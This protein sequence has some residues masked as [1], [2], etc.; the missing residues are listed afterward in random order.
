MAKIKLS[1]ALAHYDRHIPFFDG[2]LQSG[3]IDL[4]VLQVGQSVSERD[5]DNRHGRML[6]DG[7]FDAAEVS[8]S[9]YL[10]GR[11]RNL[12]FTA[13]PVFP[14]RLFS[15]SMIWVNKTAG[16]QTPADLIGKKI[17]LSSFQTTLSVLTKGDLQ[18]EY[19][20]PWRKIHWYTRRQETIDFKP[21]AGVQ[22]DLIPQESNI[23]QMFLAGDLDA[24]IM[25]HPPKEVTE[26]SDLIRRLFDNPRGEEL[27]YFQKNGFYPI[28]HVI[29]FRN[30]FL[31]KYPEAAPELV[32]LFETAGTLAR[33][34]YADPNWSLMAWGRHLYEE[35]RRLIGQNPWPHGYKRNEANLKRFIGYSFDQGLLERK[36]TVKEL[37]TESTLD[38]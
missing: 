12:P 29:A 1:L 22:I 2:T 32:D 25:P 8:L 11:S 13:I 34:H 3:K 24:L 36:L 5:G 17:G 30:E 14:R 23:G 18:S 27:K 21:E 16:I 20:V 31:E 33:E 4:N 7:E 26:G 6:K 38:S 28:M 9:S 10:M 35:E 15:L 19:G 37:F